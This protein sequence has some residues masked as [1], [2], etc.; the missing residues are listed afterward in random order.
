[1]RIPALAFPPGPGALPLAAR[2]LLFSVAYLGVAWI[3]F[4]YPMSGLNITPWNPQAALA[5]GLLLAHPRAWPAVWL[6]AACAQVL[7]GR[8]GMPM[9][10]VLASTGAL[11]LGHGALAAALR[12]WLGP[13]AVLGRRTAIVFLLTVAS[14]ALLGALLR[15]G[16]LWAVGTVPFDRLPAVVHR[17][18]IGDGVGLV[19]T[20]PLLLAFASRQ[21]RA[22]AQ[23]ML[24]SV[25]WWVIAGVTL[26][27]TVAVFEQPP[28]QQFKWFYALFVPVVWA[29][30]RFGAVGAVCSAGVVQ[31]LLIAAVQAAPY[32]PLTVF[33][34][35]LLVAALTCTG[36]LLGAI[37]DERQAAEEA[38]RASLRLAAAGDM[39]AALAHELNQPLTA[40]STYS[41]ALQLLVRRMGDDT[42]SS[43]IAEVAGKLGDEA[44]RAGDVVNRLRKFFRG[45]TTELQE[46]RLGE[47]VAEVVQAQAGRAAELDVAIATDASPAL[48]PVWADR[49]QIGVVLRNLVANAIEAV[50]DPRQAP[51][52]AR[53]V[54]V[55][56]EQRGP[57]LVVTVADTGPGL[58]SRSVREVFE[59]Q[60]S[61]KPGGMGIGLGISRAIVE[62]HGGRLWAEP[63][64]GGLFRFSLPIGTGEPLEP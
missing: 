56:V 36:L 54:R 37:V 21:H 63:G 20:L 8:E 16:A 43:A 57:E 17:A 29:A 58:G 28:G 6:A 34:L 60:G 2:T 11:T 1:M 27:A 55:G 50:S 19:V 52:K 53:S 3:S 12:R 62:A 44:A 48:P 30:T 59:A 15:A 45:R 7:V 18:F 5:V 23:A 49:V 47:L 51:G 46:T 25:E 10:A 33:E 64:P 9:A 41:R 40:M 14:G 32:Q 39:A 26:L 22:L 31:A 38:L 35:Q 24:R 4:V 42:T 13:G 61:S